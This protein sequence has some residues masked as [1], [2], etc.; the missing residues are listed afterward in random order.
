MTAALGSFV[1]GRQGFTVGFTSP[2]LL[3]LE[4]NLW[5]VS[6]AGIFGGDI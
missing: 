3:L 1:A 2:R 5:K 4:S 6:I